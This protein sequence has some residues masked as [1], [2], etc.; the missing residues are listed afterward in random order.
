MLGGQV[1]WDLNGRAAEAWEK[2]AHQT[3]AI[4]QQ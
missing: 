1:M 4:K 3:Q 2:T